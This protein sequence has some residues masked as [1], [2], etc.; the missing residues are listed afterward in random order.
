MFGKK[1]TINID[2]MSCNHC[3]KKVE[4]S[5]K[6]IDNVKNVKVNLNKK[7]ATITYK[8]NIDIND[9][10][11]KIEKLEYKYIGIDLN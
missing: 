5:L 6:E 3:A 8:D 11:N 2:G 10:K 7:N 1:L 9:I 4:D